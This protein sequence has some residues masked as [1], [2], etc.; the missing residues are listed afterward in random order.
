MKSFPTLLWRFRRRRRH[1]DGRAL[2]GRRGVERRLAPESIEQPPSDAAQI[3][4]AARSV[5]GRRIG[6]HEVAPTGQSGL[7]RPGGRRRRPRPTPA[8]DLGEGPLKLA[9]RARVDERVEA[10]VA[11][12]EP[13]AARE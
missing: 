2:L 12:A 10:A 3:G 1:G 11:V 8:Q 13:K 6:A 9:T 5:H 7:T 4:A